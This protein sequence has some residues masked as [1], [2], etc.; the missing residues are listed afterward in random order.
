MRMKHKGA[1]FLFM[2][3]LLSVSAV[4]AQDDAP[5]EKTTPEQRG[6][7]M[8]TA[9]MKGID[10]TATQKEALDKV[11]VTYATNMQTYRTEGDNKEMMQAISTKRDNSVKV[12]LN[13]DS[14]YS[15]YIMALEEMKKQMQERKKENSGM[16][17]GAGRHGGTGNGMGRNA[18]N[19]TL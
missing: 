5:R 8:E 2:M 16:H 3:L 15:Q 18:D 10:V 17:N 11:F 6:H 13:D 19:S 7:R 14:K 1:K 9:L 4:Y 12:I